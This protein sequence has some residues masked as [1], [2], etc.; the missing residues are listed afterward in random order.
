VDYH[1]GHVS[2]LKTYLYHRGSTE[3]FF[4]GGEPVRLLIVD[5]NN[6]YRKYLRRVLSAEEDLIVENEASDGEGAVLLA[7]QLKPD[8]ILMD[9][10]LP[11][12]DGLNATRRIKEQLTQTAVI[13][14]SNDE[15][16]RDTAASFGADAFL[17]K[18]SSLSEILAAIRRTQ[19]NQG[20]HESPSKP[21]DSK[22]KGVALTV[23]L[24]LGMV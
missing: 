19:S 7:Q 9:V 14:L 20:E 4:A 23:L 16:C 8:V 3:V 12:I 10:N 24:L 21:T 11:G 18:S 5:D 17:S 22:G 6:E 13:I 2:G 15:T 1:I